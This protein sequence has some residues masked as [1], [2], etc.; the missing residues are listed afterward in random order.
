VYPFWQA[1][2][3]PPSHRP[4][5]QGR[6]IAGNAG[7]DSTPGGSAR[8]RE[9]LLV[10]IAQYPDLGYGN[11]VRPCTPK[12]CPL[13]LCWGRRPRRAWREYALLARLLPDVSQ[14]RKATTLQG[15]HWADGAIG[16][17]KAIK[18]CEAV[19]PPTPCN[20]HIMQ[21]LGRESTSSRAAHRGARMLHVAMQL[22][23]STPCA[24]CYE[25]ATANN[26]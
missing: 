25:A 8:K 6:K 3:C 21:G 16:A 5:T 7:I 10:V 18:A 26:R 23:G 15:T 1:N 2:S 12:W 9:W 24:T 20:P 11:E 4:V 17:Q 19:V 14:K 22:V 13:A